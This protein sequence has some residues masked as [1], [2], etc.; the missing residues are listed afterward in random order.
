MDPR[1]AFTRFAGRFVHLGVCGSISA[2]KA[3]ELM[4][5]YQGLDIRV[6]ATL[7]EAAQRF[8]TPLTFTSLHAESVYTGMFGGT[9]SGD[10]DPFGHLTPGGEADVFVIAP[11]SATTL[12]RMARG[13]AEEILSAQCLAFPGPLVVAPAMNPR[14]WQHPA[15]QEN[16]EILQRRGAG[17]VTP[18]SGLVAC[19]DEG[20]GKLADIQTILLATLKALSPQDMAGKKVMLTLGPTREKWD[21]VRFWTNPSSGLMGS[22]LAIA[23]WLRGAEVHAVSGPGVAAL[24]PGIRQYSVVSAREMYGQAKALWPGMDIGLFTAAVA[25]FSP[26]PF[27]GHKFKK[28]GNATGFT[29][30]FTPNPDILAELSTNKAPHQRV[31][32]FAAETDLLEEHVAAKLHKKQA[33][34]IAGNLVGSTGAGFGAPT[35]T[36]F[37]LDAAG[38]AEHWQPASKPDVAWRLLDW[39]LTL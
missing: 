4:R 24:P 18:A 22:S 27:G 10:A 34:M 31:L 3:I 38:K 8:V 20:E 17:I 2:Y 13:S 26:Q 39:L 7:T 11:A 15:T 1:F 21:G 5:L 29:V 30:E 28:Q 12:A 6:S 19:G 32:G 25:D 36:M 23:A 37:V 16:V 35:N 9:E 33:H 14:M